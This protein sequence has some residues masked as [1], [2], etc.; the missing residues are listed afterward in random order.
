MFLPSALDQTG[1]QGVVR[2][3]RWQIVVE[4]RP[5]LIDYSNPT[6]PAMVD[7]GVKTEGVFGGLV[8]LMSTRKMVDSQRI[9]GSAKG[10]SGSSP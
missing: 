10:G 5:L 3:R 1:L 9:R 6:S 7:R 4:V 8:E 2:K